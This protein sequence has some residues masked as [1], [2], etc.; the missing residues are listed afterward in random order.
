[1]K[2]PSESTASY[3][4]TSADTGHVLVAE[5][6]ATSGTTQQSVLSI[7]ALVGS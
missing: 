2:I 5:V 6:T 3:E 1:V 4:P 7:G